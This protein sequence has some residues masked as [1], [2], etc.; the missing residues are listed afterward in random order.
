M[1]PSNDNVTQKIGELG[2]VVHANESLEDSLRRVADTALEV[3]NRCDAASVS[4]AKEGQVSTWVTTES[5]AER[6]DQ[7]QYRSDE[8]PC[9]EAIRTGEST[10]VESMDSEERWPSFTAAAADEGMVAIYSLPLRI[11]AE[12]VGALN[13]YSRSKAFAYRDLQAAEALAAQAAVT[14]S[15]AEA[16]EETRQRVVHLEEAL[17]S[18]DPSG[19]GEGSPVGH[20]C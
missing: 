6:V 18:R 12:T 19:D 8:G 11:G 2:R 10:F 17:E 9:L 14:L 15:N 3:I 1:A 16:Y 7:H 13:L 4:M 20:D 5:A